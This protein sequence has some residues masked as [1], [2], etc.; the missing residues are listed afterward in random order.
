MCPVSSTGVCPPLVA[1]DGCQALA[2]L[3]TS[4]DVQLHLCMPAVLPLLTVRSHPWIWPLCGPRYPPL[5]VA[6]AA[7]AGRGCCWVGALQDEED[8]EELMMPHQQ[9]PLQ[10]GRACA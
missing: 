3:T 6:A 10:V 8:E 2:C 7:A 5:P 1:T 4:C 9:H